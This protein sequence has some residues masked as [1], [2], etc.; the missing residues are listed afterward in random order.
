MFTRTCFPYLT[1][2]CPWRQ[3]PI[4]VC[5][6]TKSSPA[7]LLSPPLRAVQ[8]P[9]LPEALRQLPSGLRAEP[10]LPAVPLMLAL[11]RHSLIL[12]PRLLPVP[13]PVL[14]GHGD[15]DSTP[16]PGSG[17]LGG[18]A[19]SRLPSP[20]PVPAKFSEDPIGSDQPMLSH[21]SLP[22]SVSPTP[23][24]QVTLSDRARKLP[25]PRS[26]ADTPDPHLGENQLLPAPL[27]QTAVPLGTW[28]PGCSPPRAVTWGEGLVLSVWPLS[29][30]T[31]CLAQSRLSGRVC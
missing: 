8:G 15:K 10:P 21:A 5:L 28:P 7:R 6:A 1:S 29:P 25:S 24:F 3:A 12:R 13:A 20:Q 31:G 23:V 11:S 22:P 4:D 26:P 9:H 19:P 17:W 16:H 27:W 2:F 30:L 18:A 14:W